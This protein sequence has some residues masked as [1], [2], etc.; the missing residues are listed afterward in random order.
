MPGATYYHFGVLQ[1]KVHMIWTKAICGY[2]DFRPRYSTDVVFNNFPW[3][4]VSQN[5]K[6]AIETT[7]KKI[8]E[9]RKRY[10]ESCLA[11]LYDVATMPDDL[12]KAHL[13]NDKAVMKAYGF[14]GKTDKEVT[15]ALLKLYKK[16]ISE[17]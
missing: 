17:K 16:L 1:S 2:K 14:T 10:P 15:K 4:D 7:A 9:V 13:D 3:P 5:D 8:L 12:M 6:K 11:D